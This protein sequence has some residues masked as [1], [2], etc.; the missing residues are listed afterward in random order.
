M[1]APDAPMTDTIRLHRLRCVVLRNPELAVDH[2]RRLTD[3][4]GRAVFGGVLEAGDALTIDLR[5]L[6]AESSLRIVP[7]EA[8]QRRRNVTAALDACHQ[9]A[10]AAGAME[11]V[12]WRRLTVALG[13]GAD[14]AVLA[15][16]P[17]AV[18]ACDGYVVAASNCDPPDE[19]R[20]VLAGGLRAVAVY[21]HVD[22][23]E[24][25]RLMATVQLLQ[26]RQRR[27]SELTAAMFRRAVKAMQ[28]GCRR[29]GGYHGGARHPP[30]LPGG[31]LHP[32]LTAPPPEHLAHRIRARPAA[33]S[34]GS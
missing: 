11:P 26:S 9:A 29:H 30:S 14:I 21:H 15:G 10:R 17:E 32:G 1:I 8:D 19:R 13:V 22:C 28:D 7:A 23:A 18:E 20:V 12:D 27:S 31:V 3:P 16:L 34:C 33:H 6:L 25:R 5:I 24:G 4:A 2:L